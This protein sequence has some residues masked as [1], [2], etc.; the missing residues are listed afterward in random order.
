MRSTPGWHS[1]D[2]ADDD[3]PRR[4]LAA[5]G[6]RELADDVR[7][8]PRPTAARSC[9]GRQLGGAGQVQERRQRRRAARPAP[10]ADHL[11]DRR[12]SAIARP[13]PLGGVDEGERRVGGAEIDADDEARCLALMAARPPPA[14]P[15]TGRC[16]RAERR[17]ACTLATR[18]PWWRSVPVNGGSPIDVADEPDARGSKPA[19][20]RD[21]AR[22][23]RR[24]STG[25]SG[26]CSASAFLQP[27]WTSRTAAPISASA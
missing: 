4:H 12:T 5:A 10:G 8:G 26:M 13:S 27:R 21:R 14:R 9:A 2:F 6:A 19:S 22:S 1:H 20:T 3:Q 7:R 11:R 17:A 23:P 25:S 24:R 16:P 18:Q 15:P